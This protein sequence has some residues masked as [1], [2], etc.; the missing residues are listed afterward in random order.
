MMGGRIRVE[1]GVGE[2]STFSFTAK[3]ARVPETGRGRRPDRG[4]ARWPGVRVLVVDDNHTNRRILEEVL[5]NWGADPVDGPRRPL[6]ARRAPLEASD[7]RPALR[8]RPDRRHDA[9]RW[10]ASMLARAD[11]RRPGRLDSPE[12][13]HADLG[14]PVG[15]IRPG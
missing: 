4:Q 1:S 14:G 11:R 3:F 8:P 5:K 9:R 13:D 15:R 10:T 7:R 2:G 6:G 12:D